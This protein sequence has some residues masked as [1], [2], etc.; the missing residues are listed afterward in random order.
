MTTVKF[1]LNYNFSNILAMDLAIDA[2]MQYITEHN[3]T[4]GAATVK[5]M[6]LAMDENFYNGLTRGDKCRVGRGISKLVNQ[7]E[8]HFLE[9]GEKKGS[10]NT[11]YVVA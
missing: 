10:T 4:D 9:R 7:G 8:I 11:Y 1:E 2:V 3:E 5:E 6:I